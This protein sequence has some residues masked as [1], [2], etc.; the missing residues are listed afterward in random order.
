MYKP[1]VLSF[2][3]MNVVM[4]NGILLSDVVLSYIML[5]GIMLSGVMVSGIMLRGIMLSGIMLSVTMLG[6][7]ML[8]G[9]MLSGVMLNVFMLNGVMLSVVVPKYCSLFRESSEN[10]WNSF[11]T[12]TTGKDVFADQ[13]WT[14]TEW[15][16][17]YKSLKPAMGAATLGITTLGIM[18]LKRTRNA[19]FSIT[20][21]CISIEKYMYCGM[22]ADDMTKQLKT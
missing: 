12:L 18:T 2:V 1:F 21:C 9:I 4:L 20:I 13:D 22:I 6:G 14:W 10:K 8:S 7:I 11:I 19:T 3:I 5:S 16:G 15:E 17:E